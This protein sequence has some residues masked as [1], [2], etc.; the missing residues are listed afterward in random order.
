VSYWRR[1]PPTYAIDSGCSGY[2]DQRE[3]GPADWPRL[4]RLA[5]KGNRVFS[6]AAFELFRLSRRRSAVVKN[7]HD[8]TL[9]STRALSK[10]ERQ[11][12]DHLVSGR[13]N[14]QIAQRLGVTDNTVKTHVNRIYGKLE[15]RNRLCL[16]ALAIE[17]GWV[18]ESRGGRT[19]LGGEG[20]SRDL[21]ATSARGDR[22]LETSWGSAPREHH[23]C[24][25]LAGP[26]RR[27]LR[28][29]PPSGLVLPSASVFPKGLISKG[30]ASTL[31]F[32]AS[33]TSD[34]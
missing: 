19:R 32:P 5:A 20:R 26:P 28:P 21:S 9:P 30:P 13:T 27:R 23:Q 14:K 24:C 15:V 33:S 10:R 1:T 7:G 25:L 34:L 22:A 11:V 4:V 6:D 17:R 8:L 31:S 18:D 3:L 2:V 16:L 12:L 29:G